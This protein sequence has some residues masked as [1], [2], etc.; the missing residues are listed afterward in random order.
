MIGSRESLAIGR[1]WEVMRELAVCDFRLKYYD[2]TLGYLWSM[3]SPLLMIAIYYFVFTF[4]V[5]VKT[6]GYLVYLLVG[7]VYW[8][9][10]QDCTFSGLTAL[11]DKAGVLRSIHVPGIVVVM[12]G[13]LSTVITLLI[14]TTALVL[15]LALIGR[16]SPLA[17]LTL[18]P[19]LC[20]VLLA[21]GVAFLVAL[22]HVRFR[23]AGLVWGV[24]LQAFFWLTP[25]VYTVSSARVAEVVYLNPLARC[26]Y[27]I[28]WFLVYDYLPPVRFV[29]FTV[30]LCVAVF[31]SSVVL[32]CRRQD[33]IP[34]SL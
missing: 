15:V 13:A 25:V 23:D 17:P 10:F 24:L 30:V 21:A 19:L 3:L 31:V 32:F 12:G 27:L 33:L 20:L 16:L 9:F 1:H 4:I 11:S 29:L 2:S 5:G 18:I 34:E 6:P 8:M 7:I 26:L 22:V 28:R 14:N